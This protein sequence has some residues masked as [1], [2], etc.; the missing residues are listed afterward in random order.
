MA[1]FSVGGTAVPEP[2]VIIA[3]GYGAAYSAYYN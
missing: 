3:C 1:L 2:V